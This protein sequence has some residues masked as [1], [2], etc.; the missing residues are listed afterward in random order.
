MPST[1][2]NICVFNISSVH[3]SNDVRVFHKFALSLSD[4]FSSF[5][6][7]CDGSLTRIDSGVKVIDLGNARCLIRLFVKLP[8]IVLHA[9]KNKANICI[10]HDPELLLIALP[11][12]LFNIKVIYDVH[13]DYPNQILNKHYLPNKIKKP[14][15]FFFDKFEKLIAQRLNGISCATKTIESKFKEHHTSPV[16]IYNYPI[17][18]ESKSVIKRDNIVSYIGNISKCRGISQMI[19]LSKHS[20]YYTLQIAGV[21]HNKTLLKDIELLKNRGIYVG[22]LNRA[23]VSN[24]LYKSKVGLLLLDSTENYLES[25]P[26]KMFEYMSHGIPI[27]ASDFPIWRNIIDGHKCGF[28]VDPY[29]INS[30][31]KLIISLM[32]N[33]N[34]FKTMSDNCFKAAKV[35]FNWLTEKN[36]LF[37]YCSSC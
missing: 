1:K 20:N 30:I 32:N 34:L 29:D 17:I 36:K 14:V 27:I 3:K 33:D 8:L 15:S 24:L 9:V 4:K 2:N 16:T 28:L 5:L 25:L 7:T 37:K 22:F 31:N 11:L 35:H 13:E 12:K 18:T 23:G 19:K 6:I 21:C 26:I 10:L